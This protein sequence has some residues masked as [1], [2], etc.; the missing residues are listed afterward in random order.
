MWI[1]RVGC[2]DAENSMDGKEDTNTS[3]VKST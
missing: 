1:W 3:V 2:D